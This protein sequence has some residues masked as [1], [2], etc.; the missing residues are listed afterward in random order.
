MMP[1]DKVFHLDNKKET[2]E[3]LLLR[4]PA[5]GGYLSSGADSVSYDEGDFDIPDPID[6]GTTGSN[7]LQRRR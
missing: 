6:T 7:R 3:A 5:K 2:E 1:D 4:W